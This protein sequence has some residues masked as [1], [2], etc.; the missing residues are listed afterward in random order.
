MAELFT[1]ESVASG[2]PD[3]LCDRISDTILDA[4]LKLDP[5]SKVGC[6]VM[7]A[8]HNIVIGGEISTN[9]EFSDF[10]MHE[11]ARRTIREIGYDQKNDYDGAK[12]HIKTLLNTQSPDIAQGVDTG[13]AGDQGLM[14]GYA[15]DHT[16]EFMPL[17]IS[18]SHQLTRAYEESLTDQNQG[19]FGPDMKAQVTV[20]YHQGKPTHITNVLISAQHLDP[21]ADPNEVR[22]RLSELMEETLSFWW[23]PAIQI[24]TNP[25]G[26]FHIG[27]PIGDCGLTGRKIIVDTYGGSAPHGGGA[28][29][30]KD[31]SKVDRS[32]A[33]M[34]RYIAKNVVAHTDTEEC[35]V[36]LAYAIGQAEPV[37]FSLKSKGVE[38]TPLRDKV[39]SLLDL[40][41][42]GIIER[43]GLKRPIYQKTS[44]GG[45]FGREYDGEF[46]PWEALDLKL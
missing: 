32:A 21:D 22:Q 46:F 26:K 17:P 7:A 24:L 14:F 13:G 2:H 4:H 44:S 18:L 15:V 3:K 6:E 33:Y 9:A 34:A 39:S 38:L 8:G 27:G 29:S 45:H 16:L 30:G 23:N 25:T 1:S 28:F 41:P 12:V 37:S 35:L 11:L 10:E 40:R 36:Q 42:A 20:N 19:Y 43:L 31:P 5:D